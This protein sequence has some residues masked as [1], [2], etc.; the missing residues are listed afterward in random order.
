MQLSNTFISSCYKYVMMESKTYRLM[1]IIFT[2]A[3]F[4][5]SGAENREN[6]VLSSRKDRLEESLPDTLVRRG[7]TE[8]DDGSEGNLFTVKY[9]VT[10]ELLWLEQLKAMKYVRGRG[11][12]R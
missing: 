10:V 9:C 7:K 5:N 6:R 3:S 12:W 2:A 11:S 4:R 8:T 1:L